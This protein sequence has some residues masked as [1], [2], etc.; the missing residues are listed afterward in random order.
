MFFKNKE[1]SARIAQLEQELQIFSDIQNDLQQEM[2]SFWLDARGV[3]AGVNEN[4]C[5]CTGYGKNELVGRQF[6][7]LLVPSSVDKE[8]CRRMLDSIAQGRHW[9]GAVQLVK[10][11][12]AEA[13]LRSI[14][15]PRVKTSGEP[16][17][18]VTYSTELTR[19][20]SESRETQDMMQALTRSSAV[21]EFTLDGIIL[22][23]NDNFLRCVGYSK[24]DIVGKHHRL[25]CT[26][27]TAESQEYRDFW[28]RLGRGEFVSDRFQRVGRDGNIIWLE[29][30]Y[31]P[32]RDETGKYYKVVK[33]ATDITEQMKRE[34][35]ISE[36]SNIAYE[37]SQKT[38]AD[39]TEGLKVINSTVETMKGLSALMQDASQGINELDTQ[40]E[41]VSALVDSIKGIADQTNLLALNAA[42]EA[43]RAGEQG[44]G[45]SVVAD[46][47]RQ[48]A[49]RTSAATEQIIEVVSENK[50]LTKKSVSLI[51][52]SLADAER[53]LQLSSESG[54]MMN[55]IQSSAR[56]VVDAVSEFKRTL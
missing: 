38:D 4:F 3:I 15:Q 7:D 56:Q 48:L 12:G 32:I 19:T 36:T 44:R 1:L 42:I 53:A 6:Q 10:K 14:F 8:H 39:S 16:T 31:N 27:E 29:A 20:I 11:N 37:I 5:D 47:V 51:E 46:E 49:S 13:W 52:S 34:A 23:A 41:R 25:F 43:A 35:A 9:H 30:S 22:N 26:R 45:F 17:E 40:S 24:G 2:I 28:Q 50:Q 18:L 55:E 54:S 33:F 21:I